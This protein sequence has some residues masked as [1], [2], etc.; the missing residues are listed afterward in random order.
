VEP[1]PNEAGLAG[2]R[3][4]VLFGLTGLLVFT[5][6]GLPGRGSTAGILAVG[7]SAAVVAAVTAR[8]PWHRWRLEATLVLVPVAFVMIAFATW[9]EVIPVRSYGIEFVLVFAWVG[10]HHRPGVALRLLPLAAMGYVLPLLAFD[11]QPAL[12]PRAV[13]LAMVVCLLV[14]EVIARGQAESR[15]AKARSHAAVAAL[16]AMTRPDPSPTGEGRGILARVADSAVVLGYDGVSLAIPDG[17]DTFTPQEVRGIATP[18]AG[19]RYPVDGG[20]TGAVLASGEVV[21]TR[22]YGRFA[23]AFRRIA[24]AGV[25]TVIGVPIQAGDVVVGVLNVCTTGAFDA[26]EQDIEALE[27]LAEVAGAALSYGRRL[28]DAESVAEAESEAAR[29]DELTGCFNRREGDR[30]IASMLPGDVVALVDVDDFGEVNT[31]LGHAG[32]DR[33]LVALAEHLR[34]RLRSEDVVVRHGG[35]EFVLILPGCPPEEAG[36]ILGRLQNAWTLAGH[37]V[38]FS[39]GYAPHIVGR[40]PAETLHVAD[41]ALYAAKD[42]GRDRVHAAV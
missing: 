2:R 36:A 34:G 7:A 22:D 26:T 5:G 31:T 24:E 1:P 11:V 20:V 19:S 17:G 27:A 37:A 13:L 39:V 9:A 14:A 15:N 6:F 35:D 4:A 41:Q 23:G 10:L 30:R 29:T 38:T 28:E 16:R 32:G 3:A 18:L 8:L 21:V 25:G 40:T 42:A 12:D 33:L